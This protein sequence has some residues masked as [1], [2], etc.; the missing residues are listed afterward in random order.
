L[1]TLGDVAGGVGGGDGVG[2]RRPFVLKYAACSKWLMFDNRAIFKILF[3]EEAKGGNHRFS[4][5]IG[6]LAV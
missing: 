2:S 1:K 4:I 6:R 5:V 3:K